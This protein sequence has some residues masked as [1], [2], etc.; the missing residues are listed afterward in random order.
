[1]NEANEIKIFP[2]ADAF[3][4]AL[5]RCNASAPFSHFVAHHATTRAFVRRRRPR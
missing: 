2:S 3:E 4:L 5:D 1:M